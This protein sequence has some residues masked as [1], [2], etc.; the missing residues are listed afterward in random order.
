MAVPSNRTTAPDPKPEPKIFTLARAVL[1]VSVPCG[2]EAL[3]IPP[4]DLPSALGTRTSVIWTGF[5]VL[6]EAGPRLTSKILLLPDCTTNAW[7]VAGSAASPPTRFKLPS[8][9][10]PEPVG[11]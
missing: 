5:N 3:E 4:T 7:F 6:E 8:V 11:S 1:E 2:K 9:N 10:V